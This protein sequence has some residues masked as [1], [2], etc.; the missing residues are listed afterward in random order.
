[1]D[2]LITV[3]S[4]IGGIFILSTFV[5]KKN[6]QNVCEA[7]LKNN[8]Q[9]HV[10]YADIDYALKRTFSTTDLNAVFEYAKKQKG[11]DFVDYA[12]IDYALKKAFG[13]TDLNAV[14]EHYMS[15]ENQKK[16]EKYIQQR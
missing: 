6:N 11:K 4:V 5:S 15:F 10:D 1:M 14:F 8:S 13:T 9:D 2:I 12:D 16:L 3:I 7:A